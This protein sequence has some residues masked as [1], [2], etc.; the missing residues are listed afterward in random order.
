[1]LPQ[2]DSAH[3]V[4]AERQPQ[5]AV[6]GAVGV[7]Q[8]E[9]NATAGSATADQSRRRGIAGVEQLN[10][11]VALHRQQITK[12]SGAGRPTKMASP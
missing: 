12:R 2:P 11:V 4:I 8:I 9:A 6:H 1:M 10:V 7:F 3:A 5:A